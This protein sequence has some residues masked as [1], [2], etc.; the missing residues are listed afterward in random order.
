MPP[1]QQKWLEEEHLCSL[2]EDKLKNIYNEIVDTLP[3]KS[4]IYLPTE[5]VGLIDRILGISNVRQI[6]TN[7]LD[8]IYR[9]KLKELRR[10]YKNYSAFSIGNGPSLNKTDLDA[11]KD[12]ITF[13][14]NGFLKCKDL[15]WLPTFYL[16][17][18]H[19]V[20]ED[21]AH[22]INKLKGPS[23]CSPLILGMPSRN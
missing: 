21:R 11:L 3:S 20:A 7:D 6:Y 18:D 9:P 14:V 22:W 5:K 23:N 2:S 8:K 19:L 16:V 12:E 13:A 17:E 4:P 1:S 10:K 15:A